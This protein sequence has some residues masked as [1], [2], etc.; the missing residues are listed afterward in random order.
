MAEA[1][2]AGTPLF[3][4]SIYKINPYVQALI[5]KGYASLLTKDSLLFS[6]AAPP[7]IQETKRV[8]QLLKEAYAEAFSVPS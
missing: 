6:R 5:Q 3:I 7:L 8:A 1:T 2:S 4:Y